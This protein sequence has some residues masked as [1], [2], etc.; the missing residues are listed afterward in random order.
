MEDILSHTAYGNI[1]GTSLIDTL[2]S[3][4]SIRMYPFSFLS[5]GFLSVATRHGCPP[6][7]GHRRIHFFWHQPPMT[8]L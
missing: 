4:V 1:V 2:I 8:E 5:H 6:L 3:L 7:D